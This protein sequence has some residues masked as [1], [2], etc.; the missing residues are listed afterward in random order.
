MADVEVKDMS[1]IYRG[2][3]QNKVIVLADGDSLPEGTA[4]EVRAAV[5]HPDDMPRIRIPDAVKEELLARGLMLEFKDPPMVEPDGDR[6][7]IEV[8]GQPLSEMIIEDRR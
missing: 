2:T 7:P 5:T 4:V 1:K 6:T 3:V 8:A